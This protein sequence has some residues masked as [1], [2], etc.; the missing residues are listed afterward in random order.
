MG[1]LAEMQRRLLEQMMGPEAMGVA[2][3]NL[4]WSDDKVCRNFLCGTCPHTLFTNT[5]MDLGACPKSHTERLKTEFL[6]EREASPNDP[7]FLRFQTEYESNIFAFVDECDRRIRT[8]QRR[9]EKTPEENAKTTNLMREIAEIELA[10]Q[11]GTE[12]I[13][14]LGEQGKVEESMKE[15]AA[16]EALKSEKG[17]KERELQQLTDTSGASGHQKLRVCDVC[18]AY[19]SVLDSDRRLA[20]HFGGKVCIRSSRSVGLSSPSLSSQ[21]HLG[22]HELRNMLLKFKEDREKRKSQPAPSAPSGGPPGGGPP[23]GGERSSRDDFR[24]RDRDGDRERGYDRHSSR[25]E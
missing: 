9:L 24:D 17:E 13:E 19:L 1:R 23:R 14:T 20:D 12:K 15:M 8:A 6:A 11:G 7:I 10:I 5:K 3:A 25:Y 18:G 16:I 4:V 22:Y 2:N 21:M